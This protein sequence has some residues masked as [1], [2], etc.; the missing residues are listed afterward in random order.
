MR[1]ASDVPLGPEHLRP[2]T[3]K[4]GHMGHNS[5]AGRVCQCL[6]TARVIH[7][8][9][10]WAS[11]D[12]HT[13]HEAAAA[14]VADAHSGPASKVPSA[15]ARLAHRLG[16][17]RALAALLGLAAIGTYVA[18]ALTRLSYPLVLE[19]LES[20]SLIEVHRILAGQPL[21]ATP[22]AGYVPDGY[23]PL[24]FAVSSA[25]AGVLG[26]SYLPLRL[27]SLVSSLACF[28]VLGRLVQRE[29]GSAAAGMAAAG[30]LAGTYFDARTW[31][32][33]ARV[34]SLF[35]ALSVTALYAAR[36][37]SRTRGAVAA[38]LLLGAAFLTKQS[39]L[40]EGVAVLAALAAGPRRRLAV[41]AALTYG[42]VLAGSTLVLGLTSHGWYLYY[43][44]E[45]MG[46]HALNTAAETRFWT[47]YLLPTLGIAICAA[48]TGT[49]RIPL[50]LSAGCAALVAEGYAARVQIGGNV[51]D[52]LP[53]YLVV[54]LLAGLAMTP[55][56]G[57]QPASRTGRPAE[58]QDA[59]TRRGQARRWAAAAAAGLV[60]AQLAVL[61][62]GFRPGNAIP[63]GADR[64]AGLRLAAGLE[65]LGGTVAIPGNPSLAL[66]AGLP[67]VENQVAA[68]DVLGA[69]DRAAKTIFTASVARA[70]STQRF[71]AI[72][73]EMTGDLRG[74]PADLSRYYRLCPQMPL[75][76]APPDPYGPVAVAR[77]R[78]VSV[79]LP[80]GR[81]SC[82]A[83][84]RAINGA[85][86]M[87]SPAPPRVP[88]RPGGPA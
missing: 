36:W 35:L 57:G 58:A 11:P 28:A 40:A 82:A 56:P 10:P 53:A 30:L 1:V 85:Q 3:A 27:V 81:G 32:D 72:I 70:V 21:Y 19:V 64:A 24:Y 14:A 29:T 42:A 61:M 38:G 47:A 45:Q 62:A 20:N 33:I 51:N 73:T 46:Q 80:A 66:M 75:A 13:G 44:F 22:S 59:D 2:Q 23:P 86:S 63:T 12:L 9:I 50:V 87:I 15:L 68:A 67:E 52:M 83:T 4:T 69:S 55:R 16:G 37:A 77:E 71:T 43:V 34:D 76:G 54:A 79:W 74:F 49:R 60:I 78:P 65:A 39:A 41:P 5:P 48:V 25:A 7:S 26:Q 6:C 31:F 8:V 88:G 17:L 18:V 84:I